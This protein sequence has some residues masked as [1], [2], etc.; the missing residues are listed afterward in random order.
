[1]NPN[2]FI[3]MLRALPTAVSE[4][5]MDS[6]HDEAGDVFRQAQ[7][8]HFATA[9]DHFAQSWKPR[10]RNYPWP[11]LRKTRKMMRATVRK[12]APGNVHKSNG[13]QLVLGISGSD[14]PYAK[15]HHHGTLKMPMRRFLYL[16]KDE[17]KK[18]HPP[19]RSHLLNVFNRT[20]G[21]IRG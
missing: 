15:F 8:D 5:P 19:I 1:M 12:G 3:A 10:T 16:R 11:I 6:L 14:V 18:L 20:R 2:Q 21:R 17:Q 4:T 7:S 13:R 9:T